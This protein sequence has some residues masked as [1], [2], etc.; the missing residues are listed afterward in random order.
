VQVARQQLL[1]L[2]EGEGAEVPLAPL[3]HVGRRQRRLLLLLLLL[4]GC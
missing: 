4:R 1:P 2:R 3:T